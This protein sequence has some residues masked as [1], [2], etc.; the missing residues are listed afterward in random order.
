MSISTAA[1]ARSPELRWNVVNG[2]SIMSV[3]ILSPYPMIERSSGDRMP[4]FRIAF[5]TYLVSRLP[6][7][8]TAV[9]SLR[10]IALWICVTH[11]VSSIV[12]SISRISVLEE[13]GSLNPLF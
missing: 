7:A 6:L 11:Q 1:K 12:R 3:H 10:L 8:I 2:G 4:A 9:G 13:D 5:S